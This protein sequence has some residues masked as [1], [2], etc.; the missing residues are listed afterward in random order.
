MRADFD[1]LWTADA[2]VQDVLN[3][4]CTDSASFFTK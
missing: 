2:N 4:A 1:K 3:A